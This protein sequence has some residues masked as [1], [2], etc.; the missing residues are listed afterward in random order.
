MVVAPPP[1]PPSPFPSPGHTFKNTPVHALVFSMQNARQVQ[2]KE[3]QRDRDVRW[4]AL[5]DKVAEGKVAI[6]RA[7]S[8]I[9][10][11]FF[12]EAYLHAPLSASIR[13]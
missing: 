1:P 10:I 11:L 9:T 7:P 13:D 5:A 6:D 4:A 3:R 12:I 2:Q 8:P